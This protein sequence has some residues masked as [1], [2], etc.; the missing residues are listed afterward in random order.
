[1]T[2][3]VVRPVPTRAA[4]MLEQSGVHPLLARLFAARGITEKS[5]LATRL[6]NLLPPDDLLGAGEAAVLLADTI[7]AGRRI[8]IVADYDCDGAT[9]CAVGL[10]ALRAMGA[11]VDY[12]V[13]NRFDTGY[14]LSPEVVR[15]AVPMKPDLIVT[16]DNGIASVEGV[17]EARRLGIA[18]LITDHHLPGSELPAADVIVNPNQPGCRFPSKAAAG[19]AVM[20]YVMLALRAE[21]RKRGAFSDD[22]EPN[23]AD[24][25]DLVALGTVADV[26]PLDRNN[27]VLVTQGLQRIRGGRMHAGI[28][29]LFAVAG[30]DP[31]QAGTFDLGF[32]LGPRINAAGR[33]AD[34]ALGIEALITDDPGRALNIAGQLDAIN[35]ER[36]TIEADMREAASILLDNLDAESRASLVLFD[37]EWHQGVIGILAG[38]VKEQLHRP[39]FAFARGNE[40]E[41]KGSGRSIPGLHLRDALDLVAKRRPNLLKRFGGHAAA[42]G[43]TLREEGLAEFEAEFE[44]VARELIAPEE[45][46]RT[47]VTDGALEAGYR[48]LDTARLLREEVWGQGFPAPVFADVFEVES[49]KLV[50]DK[51]L[52]LSLREGKTR[53]DAIRF[54]SATPA[55]ARIEAAYRLDI[56][57]WNGLS[58]VQLLIEDFVAAPA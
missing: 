23:L 54:N 39:T 43:L 46:Q 52:K 37:P 15:L 30:R 56:N 50:K 3:I 40:G 29:A 48:G 55:P 26:V 17:A 33:L 5:A 18:T 22:K 7:A 27:R 16:V 9:A 38:R 36:R 14:G 13:P 25:L 51:H 11:T 47:L 53:F 8:L 45:L 32:A 28:K 34:M 21:L 10:R 6:D 20:F 24:L 19:V 44:A 49:Q 1:M 57:E 42:A 4:L 12:L 31:A 2:R 41:I 58:N 35:R